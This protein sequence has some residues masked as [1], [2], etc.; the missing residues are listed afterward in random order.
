MDRI[1]NKKIILE[2]LKENKIF[3]FFKD[4]DYERI[5]NSLSFVYYK[6]GSKV[7]VKD[8]EFLMSLFEGEID[9]GEARR[10]KAKEVIRK[11]F[12]ALSAIQGAHIPRECQGYG[13][14]DSGESK[15]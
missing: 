7:W 1:L 3:P 5:L 15:G 11:G 6:K 14:H 2:G 13:S 4:E 12:T 9:D 8:S 10:I